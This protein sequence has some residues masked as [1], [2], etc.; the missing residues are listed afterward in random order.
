MFPGDMQHIFGMAVSR[1]KTL[2]T[3]IVGERRRKNKNK[4][5]ERDREQAGELKIIFT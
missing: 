1:R 4:R 3:H 5:E 2:K